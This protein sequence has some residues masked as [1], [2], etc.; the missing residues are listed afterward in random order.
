MGNNYRRNVKKSIAI[1]VGIS[2][3]GL[4]S[5][6]Y[7]PES[8]AAEYTL[9]QNYFRFYVD[10]DATKP[11]DPWPLGVT[12]LGE[13][14]AIASSDLPPAS[15]ERLR[16]RMSITVGSTTLSTSTESFKLQYGVVSST[17]AG[18]TSWSDTG[19]VASSTI[20]RGF[21][22][23][24]SDGTALSGNP[25]TAGDLVL[26]I[27]DRA[28][29]YEEENATALNPFSVGVGEDV[30]YDWALQDNGA[31]PTT[32]YCFRM[33]KSEGT[34]F[35]AYTFYPTITTSG[36]RP[37]T[38]NWRWYNDETNETPSLA[39][40]VENGT[41]SQVDNGNI[42]KL[43]ITVAETANVAG[44]NEKFKIQ[45]SEYSDFSQGVSNAIE[46]SNCG[47][48]SGWCYGN[49]IDNDNDTISTR[50]LTDSLV[51]GVHNESGSSTSTFDP[52]ATTTTEFEFTLK[53][54]DAPE[55]STFFF[56]L[57]DTGSG[58]AVP[59]GASNSFPSLSTA[60]GT[61][62]FTVGGLSSGTNTSG[63]VTDV[64]TTATA[65][66]F[67]K[68][69]SSS[70][71]EAAQRLT[72]TTNATIGYIL[73]LYQTQLLS[74]DG[75]D[76][77]PTVSGTNASPVA[78]GIPGGQTGAYGYHTTDATLGGG[79]A[80]R[81]ADNNT[82][83][84]LDSTPREVAYSSVPVIDESTDIVFKIELTST[85]VA[86]TYNNTLVYVLTPVF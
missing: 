15:G 84:Q 53:R 2:Q 58:L 80:T 52:P 72:V 3:I 27:S 83:A 6:F 68:V 31:N 86:G 37:E 66:P 24:V 29:S 16:L 30:E 59:K 79:V 14:V 22:G 13:N 65:I 28:G 18:V 40:A 25:P 46:L 10:N 56:R 57:F 8:Y 39:L 1:I 44:N 48:Y 85:Q 73:R 55:N 41:P 64:T 76:V 70:P 21:N 23:T 54:A 60:S 19:G 17:C 69:A 50:V 26:S 7:V 42:V 81:F 78:W 77:V 43:R 38:R 62:I 36:Y 5:F 12:D 4:G 9:T 47:L 32:T 20:W 51:S 74:S 11:T 71:V 33:V 61:L 67:G 34:A 45:Y 82:Y 35:D 75:S 63:I 49:G